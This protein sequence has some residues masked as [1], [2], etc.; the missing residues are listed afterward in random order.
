MSELKVVKS[1]K[2]DEVLR[3]SFNELAKKVFSLDFENW[4]QNGYWTGRYNPYSVVVDGKVVSN[5][6]V[7]RTDFQW[8]GERKCLIQL[9]TVMTDEA[10]RNK[11]YSRRIMEEIERDY[12]GKVDGMYLFG[13]DSV[14]NFYPKFGFVAAEQYQYVK[15]VCNTKEGTMEQVPMENK[16]HWDKLEEIIQSSEHCCSFDM[17]DNSQ[18]NMFYLSQFMQENVFYSKELEVYAVAEIEGEELQLDMI[19]AK[20]QVDVDAVVE[21][22]GRNIKKVKLGFAPQN[23]SGFQLCQVKVDDCTLFVKGEAL[24]KLE[25]EKIM[26][27]VLAHA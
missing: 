18:L 24:K 14:L 15:E 13:N 1:Y 22:F 5:I 9:G 26:F 2:D 19:M 6:S 10:Y 3:A 23:A 12:A 17:V 27:P 16:A 11:G 25:E 21:A 4:Y 7:N 8:N 20:K